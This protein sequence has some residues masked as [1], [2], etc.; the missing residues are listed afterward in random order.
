MVHL[1]FRIEL[2]SVKSLLFESCFSTLVFI[3]FHLFTM[4]YGI[5]GVVH[6][7]LMYVC[8]W[9]KLCLD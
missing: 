9:G 5:C 7:R 3:S 2:C 6:C 8:V 4:V 1:I